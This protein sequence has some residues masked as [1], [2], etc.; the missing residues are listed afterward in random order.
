MESDVMTVKSTGKQYS[1]K[2]LG[3]VSSLLPAPFLLPWLWQAKQP[4]QLAICYHYCTL[5]MLQFQNIALV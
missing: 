4:L 5:A 2:P 1:L 3:E